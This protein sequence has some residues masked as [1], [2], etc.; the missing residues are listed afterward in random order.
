MI[1]Y[2][3][4]PLSLQQKQRNFSERPNKRYRFSKGLSKT[5]ELKHKCFSSGIF[6]NLIS[7]RVELFLIE[8]TKIVR[9]LPLKLSYINF[10]LKNNYDF[11]DQQFSPSSSSCS[12]SETNSFD[13][14][15]SSSGKDSGRWSC[16]INSNN[17]YN[18]NANTNMNK[19][20]NISLTRTMSMNKPYISD[21]M[22]NQVNNYDNQSEI[23]E[24]QKIQ[25]RKKNETGNL[26]NNLRRHKSNRVNT[27]YDTG[28][29]KSLPFRE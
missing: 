2:T 15:S 7:A 3:V 18:N 5:A 23:T 22:S 10:F 21:Y 25:S 16:S 1:Q 17:N 26:E 20:K 9:S 14:G 4:F 29:T 6:G 24:N 8:K 12:S 28:C 27:F 13:G 11:N 19:I